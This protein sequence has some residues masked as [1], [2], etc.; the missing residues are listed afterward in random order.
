MDKNL[1][2]IH[3]GGPTAVINASLCGA[4]RQAQAS[5]DVDRIYVAIGGTGGLLKEQA[6]SVTLPPGLAAP[7]TASISSLSD[8]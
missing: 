4:I 5:P 2:I 7:R 1:V 6:D 3:G 8:L